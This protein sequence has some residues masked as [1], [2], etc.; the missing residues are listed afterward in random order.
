M[1]SIKGTVLKN[2]QLGIHLCALV[3]HDNWSL[4]MPAEDDTGSPLCKTAGQPGKWHLRSGGPAGTRE[5]CCLYGS[6]T[7]TPTSETPHPLRGAIGPP[8]PNH[9]LRNFWFHKRK[10]SPKSTF[11]LVHSLQI[12]MFSPVSMRCLGK[13]QVKKELD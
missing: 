4:K 8:L 9:L 1:F 2:G 12:C 11:S 13:V 10:N 6:A 3:T 7:G 5:K